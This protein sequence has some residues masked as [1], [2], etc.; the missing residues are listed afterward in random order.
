MSDPVDSTNSDTAFTEERATIQKTIQQLTSG[1]AHEVRN[2]LNAILA[3]VEALYQDL[4]QYADYKEYFDQLNIQTRRISSL[5]QYLVEIGNP[6]LLT[7]VN[8]DFFSVLCETAM[9]SWM[10]STQYQ[11][12]SVRLIPSFE[13]RNAMLNIDIPKMQKLFFTIL[14]NAAQHSPSG[15]EIQFTISAPNNKLL[16]ICI[17]DSGTGIPAQVMPFVFDF[18]FTTQTRGRGLGLCFVR[19]TMESHHGSVMIRNNDPPP[20][21]TVEL[22]FPV[23]EEN[24]R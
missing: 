10:R 2:P 7:P 8:L 18:F 5:I 16:R 6:C 9:R 15:S 23:E 14:E 13:Q 19:Q 11:K 3:I 21:C 1:I 24:E 22:N 4:N 17:I 12:H 20:G